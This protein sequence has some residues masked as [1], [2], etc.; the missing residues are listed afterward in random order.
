MLSKEEIK[1]NYEK[2][3]DEIEAAC[4]NVDRDNDVTIVSVTKTFPEQL[5]KTCIE[6]GIGAVGENRA[7]ELRDKYNIYGDQVDWH[8]I[9]HLQR[10]KVKYI[11]D[12]VS[13]IHSV[14]SYKIAK[15][16]N[17]RAKKNNLVMNCLVQINIADEESKF[18]I[19]ITQVEKF[20]ERISKFENIQI[21][22]LMNMA[23]F[24]SDPEDARSDFRE[25]SEM[26]DRLKENPYE[27]VQM[28]QLSM[29]MSN[30]YKIAVEEGS[31]MVRVGSKIFGKRDYR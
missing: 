6:L 24:Y 5:I 12:K 2:V 25:M 7:R 21:I 28:K 4:R 29:G 3:K 19:P 20:L 17:K 18:G 16:I 27:N 26:F 9:G 10:N 23:P 15:E 14:D 11:I 1:A 13:L 31:T 22:G 8:M 30:D